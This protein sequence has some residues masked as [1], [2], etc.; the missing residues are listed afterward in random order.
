MKN[1]LLLFVSL[2]SFSSFACGNEYGSYSFLRPYQLKFHD[3]KIDNRIKELQIKLKSDSTNFK[4]WS[5][6]SLNLMKKGEV[7]S[8]LTLLK[9]IA[10]KHPKEYIVIANLGT[11]YELKNE[12]DSAL[13]YISEGLRLNPKSHRRSEWIHVAILKAKI[14]RN[15]NKD[16]ILRTPIIS[17]KLF[18]EHVIDRTKRHYFSTVQG[19]IFY[20][21]KTRA[22]F[23]PAP[24]QVITNLFLNLARLNF[25]YGTIEGA[26]TALIQ[27]EYFNDNSEIQKQIEEQYDLVTEKRHDIHYKK[28]QFFERELGHQKLISPKIYLPLWNRRIPEPQIVE[29]DTIKIDSSKNQTN[30]EPIKATKE[31]I[32][33]KKTPEKEAKK[34]NLWSLYLIGLTLVLLFFLRKFKKNVD[35]KN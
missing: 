29:I 4:H 17:E 10:I 15:R 35:E 31:T 5:D 19:Q 27:A 33:P 2:V 7:D 28:N 11:A 23:T 14:K 6:L 32:S 3:N 30:T 25:K 21:I 26:F 22:P 18:F 20:Q 16:Y 13:K 9:P 24:N 34:E 12:L 1:I 8:A